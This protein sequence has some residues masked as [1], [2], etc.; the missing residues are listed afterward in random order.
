[1]S[2]KFW[3]EW[4]ESPFNTAGELNTDRAFRLVRNE[5]GV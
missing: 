5:P 2:Q 3:S 1:M 4:I